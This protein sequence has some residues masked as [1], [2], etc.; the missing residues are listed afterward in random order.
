MLSKKSP[1]KRQIEETVTLLPKFR[2]KPNSTWWDYFL[3][4]VLMWHCQT[5]GG[6]DRYQDTSLASVK[7]LNMHYYTAVRI[8]R[9]FRA[10]LQTFP[11]RILLGYTSTRKRCMTTHFSLG[12]RVIVKIVKLNTKLVIFYLFFF[13]FL[14][15]YPALLSAL[16][17][18][19][20]SCRQEERQKIRQRACPLSFTHST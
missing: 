12:E 14:K 19:L 11:F 3:L 2:S 15:P 20:V 5:A 4:L 17:V 1:P 7:S 9:G 10:R 6:R 16:P 8:N 13:F 18:R